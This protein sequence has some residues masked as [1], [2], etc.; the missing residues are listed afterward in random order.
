MPYRHVAP[1]AGGIVIQEP[2]V[3]VGRK[4]DTLLSE[5]PQGCLHAF[6][7]RTGEQAH[8]ERKDS[9]PIPLAIEFEPEKHPVRR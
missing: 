8:S 3:N 7:K 1:S 2:A 5:V 6:D 9:V 4:P